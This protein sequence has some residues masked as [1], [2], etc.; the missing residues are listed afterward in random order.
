MIIERTFGVWKA[1]FAILAHMP[2][3]SLNKQTD[4]VIATMAIHNYIRKFSVGDDAFQVAEQETYIPLRYEGIDRD[5][6]EDDV[7]NTIYW[8]GLRD[9]I[10]NEICGS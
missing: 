1:R 3:Y 5:T 8:Q 2:S 10:A 9:A 4:I 7:N 6:A